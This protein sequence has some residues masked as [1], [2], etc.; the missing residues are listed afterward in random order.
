[1]QTKATVPSHQE[2]VEV[3]WARISPTYRWKFSRHIEEGEDQDLENSG[4]ENKL[5]ISQEMLK[6]LSRQRDDWNTVLL[7]HLQPCDPTQDKRKT[8]GL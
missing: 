2:S 8:D 7:L 1:M 4:L 3:A 5:G 6:S